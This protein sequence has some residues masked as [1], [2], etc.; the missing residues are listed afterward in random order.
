LFFEFQQLPLDA[1]SAPVADEFLVGADDP[2]A[3]DEQRQR[4]FVVG[5]ADGAGCLRVAEAMR[6]VA[7]APGFPVGNVAQLFPDMPHIFRAVRG[8]RQR[9]GLQLPGQVEPQLTARFLPAEPSPH[10]RI[11]RNGF[12]RRN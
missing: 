10:K 7:V 6:D 12:A 5:E 9:E 4:V 2:V 3:G 8:E 11:R 1:Q